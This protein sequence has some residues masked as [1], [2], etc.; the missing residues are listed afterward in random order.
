MKDTSDI[1]LNK[2]SCQTKIIMR[3]D[4]GTQYSLPG[5]VHYD[6]VQA[7]YWEKGI[8]FNLKG[9]PMIHDDGV[10]T[11]VGARGWYNSAVLSA[12]LLL[13]SSS[14]SSS[15]PPP[16]EKDTDENGPENTSSHM[17]GHLLR[18]DM[19]NL[20]KQQENSGK[21]NPTVLEIGAGAVGLVGMTMAWILSHKQ[22][23]DDAAA[24]AATAAVTTTAAAAATATATATATAQANVM[25]EKNDLDIGLLGDNNDE[26]KV[27]LTDNDVECLT[28]LQCNVTSVLQSLLEFN[29]IMH[30]DVQCNVNNNNNNNNMGGA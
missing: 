5:F 28:Q 29:A 3:T 19:I 1:S 22:F 2:Q 13:L 6:P 7:K 15:S 18:Q 10:Q 8:T 23:V 17:M 25:E 12:M 16:S 11:G 20:M 24:T 4:D 30:K 26:S 21:K 27:I 14:S 9:L